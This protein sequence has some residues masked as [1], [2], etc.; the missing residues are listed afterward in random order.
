MNSYHPDIQK[1]I[2]RFK[3]AIETLDK[4]VETQ[5]DVSIW[6]DID[7]ETKRLLELADKIHYFKHQAI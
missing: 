2:N 4:A 5:K 6:V 7:P 3:Q 1:A